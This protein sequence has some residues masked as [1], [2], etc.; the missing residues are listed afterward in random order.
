MSIGMHRRGFVLAEAAA[1][2][3]VL[4]AVGALLAVMVRDTRRQARVGECIGNLKQIGWAGAGYGSDNAERV[5]TFSW[6]AGTNPTM[7]TDLQNAPDDLTAAAYQ[8]VAII[9]EQGG[10]PNFPA[11]SAWLPHLYYSHL[12][13][14]PY[15]GRPLP[16][17]MSTCPED[18]YRRLWASDPNGY[19][20]CLYTPNPACGDSSSRRWPY[21]SSYQLPPSFYSPDSATGSA[22]TLSQASTYNTFYVPGNVMLGRRTLAEVVFPSHK[23]LLH[24]AEARHYGPRAAFY[25][26]QEAR[27]PL[28]FVDG[29]VSV[30]VTWDA[31]LGGNPGTPTSPSPTYM[32][33]SPAPAPNDWEARPLTNPTGDFVPGYYRW[34]RGGMRGRDFGGPEVPY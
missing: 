7:W 34:T 28:L 19:D 4:V 31:N 15:L 22:P 10:R 9:R 12:V 16:D 29:S 23:V 2:I 8:A 27:Q 1:C 18:R 32:T 33:Y 5:W 11:I 3:A 24:D 6:R 26:Y 17:P 14:A 30:R 25:A 21:S 13:L 20:A